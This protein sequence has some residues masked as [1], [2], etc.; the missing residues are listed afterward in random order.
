M[1]DDL[2]PPPKKP[3]KLT[4]EELLIWDYVTQQDK[5]L[6][7]AEIDWKQV[8]EAIDKPP[9][10][11]HIPNDQIESLWL[12]KPFSQAGEAHKPAPTEGGIDRNSARRLRQGK[13]TIE[14]TLDLHGMH[15]QEAFDT[16][17]GF[18]KR[19]FEQQ[20]RC[21]LIITGKGRFNTEGGFTDGVLRQQLPKWLA[22]EP[23]THWVLRHER[24]QPHH[25]GDGAF[26]ILLRRTR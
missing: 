1:T 20:K 6:P 22:A 24:A 9:P 2:P 4:R 23:C 26:Y 10:K 18:L 17:T 5:R 7:K 12:Q 25:G 21:V 19:G 15:R 11:S 13:F 16:L 8:A 14:A 3:R